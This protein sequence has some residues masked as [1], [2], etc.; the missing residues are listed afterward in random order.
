MDADDQRTCADSVR[1]WLARRADRSESGDT[2]VE[3][4]L[5]LAVIA[6][7]ATALLGAF[8]TSISA[9]AQH[10]NVVTLDTVLKSYVEQV[11]N[12]LQQQTSTS[13]TF[14][15]CATASQYMAFSQLQFTP[16]SAN[17]HTYSATLSLD[18]SQPIQ[19]LQSDNTWG[20]GCV[21]TTLPPQE[22]LLTAVASETNNGV[23]GQSESVQF[24][25]SD[26]AFAPGPATAPMWS[27]PVS[28]IVPSGSSNSVAVFAAGEPTPSLS[29][30][31][32]PTW[33]TLIDDG[34]GNGT[35]VISPDTTVSSGDYSFKLTATNFGLGGV[36]NHADETFT[37]TVSQAPKIT[38]DPT[39]TAAPA[40][41]FSIPVTATG[42]PIPTLSATG[43]PA[44]VTFTDNMNRTGTLSGS[45]SVTPG[46]YTFILGALNVAGSDSQPFTLTVSS[47]TPPAFTSASSVTVP[48][49]E[50]L[51][52][53]TIT[54][55]GAP[56][57]VITELGPL[58]T[59]VTFNGGTG[60]AT[61]SGSPTDSTPTVDVVYIVTF[62]ASNAGGSV[63]QTF[64]LTVSARS[65]PT[66]TSPS[67]NS[68]T[69][70]KKNKSFSFTVT[71]TG[72]QS[73]L[74]VTSAG[75][76]NINV[77][78]VNSTS[79]TVAGTASGTTQSYAF[80]VQN[81]DGGSVTSDNDALQVTN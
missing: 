73:G 40:A 79:I 1:R 75:M 43:L 52:P 3:V 39:Y 41:A 64:M 62:T 11:T 22:E 34:G 67:H 74:S 30:T 58:P 66:I 47:A 15:P 81:P 32:A 8:T 72:F 61:L 37:V 35:L 80:T 78:F 60:S 54:A 14:I 21:T 76:S 71:G 19:Y 16:V 23:S 12:Q 56:A 68:P 48:Y 33:V 5:A 7:T 53:I 31:G 65:H 2:L 69:T 24:S 9:T 36:Q 44:G 70:T 26:P 13:P 51:P 46:V 45:S 49:G 42:T 6:L 27:G 17:G 63:P 77:A 59:G 25:I 28:D 38:S 20:S 4:L 55:S 29:E 18:P 57:P 50:A 10:R